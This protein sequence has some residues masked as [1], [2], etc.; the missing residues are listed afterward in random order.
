MWGD[1]VG[2]RG[3]D[4]RGLGFGIGPI[5]WVWGG[6][7]SGGAA[8][9]ER[10]QDE[11]VRGDGEAGRREGRKVREVGIGPIGRFSV[12]LPQVAERVGRRAIAGPARSWA[13]RRS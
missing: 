5:G 2:A 7:P 8:G 12:A 1:L 11:D 13:R 3:D 10:K 4:G 6:P 9:G